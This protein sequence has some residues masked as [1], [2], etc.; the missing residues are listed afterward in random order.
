MAHAY[1]LICFALVCAPITNVYEFIPFPRREEIS[2]F[3]IVYNSFIFSK[4]DE[5]KNWGYKKVLQTIV[6][7]DCFN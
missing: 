1:D 5:A 6:L 2:R 7:F 4:F 3:K